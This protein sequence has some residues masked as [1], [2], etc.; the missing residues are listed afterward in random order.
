MQRAQSTQFVLELE[1]EEQSVRAP[2]P[3]Q[4]TQPSAIARPVPQGRRGANCWGMIGCGL[5]VASFVFI[6]GLAWTR[7]DFN[8]QASFDWKPVVASAEAARA[9]GDAN[10]AKSLYLQAGRLATWSDDWAGLLAAGC[11][12]HQIG[13]EGGPYSPVNTLLL[14]AMAIAEAQQNHSGMAAVASAFAGLG[15]NDLASTAWSRLPGEW[16][17]QPEESADWITAGCWHN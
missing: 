3:L 2:I 9:M 14:R 11:G 15:Q 5:L 6:V 13:R 16:V 17:E 8:K 10:G 7:P 12:L 1:R 4:G